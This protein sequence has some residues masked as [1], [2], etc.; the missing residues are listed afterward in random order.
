[1]EKSKRFSATDFEEYRRINE[2]NSSR[3]NVLQMISIVASGDNPKCY[4]NVVISKAA[5]TML[6][7]AGIEATFVV[8]RTSDSTVNISA[9]SHKTINVQRIMEK[10]GGGGHFNLAACQLR[11]CSVAQDKK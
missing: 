8:A 5:D 11:D 7:M 4:N 9:R 10:M 6:A 2:A 1:M 3:S